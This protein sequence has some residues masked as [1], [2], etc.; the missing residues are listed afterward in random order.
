MADVKKNRKK[1][2]AKNTVNST[3]KK[4]SRL[5]KFRIYYEAI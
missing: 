1:L 3:T 2:A 4:K 5:S